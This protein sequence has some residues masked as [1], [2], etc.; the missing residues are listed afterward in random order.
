[1]GRQLGWQG[2]DPTPDP[3]PGPRGAALPARAEQA[4]LGVAVWLARRLSPTESRSKFPVS[5]WGRLSTA[6]ALGFLGHMGDKGKKQLRQGCLR[7][8]P[9]AEVRFLGNGSP[10][11]VGPPNSPNPHLLLVFS[12]PPPLRL[13]GVRAGGQETEPRCGRGRRGRRAPGCPS[14]EPACP[15]TPPRRVCAREGARGG[16]EMGQQVCFRPASACS[17]WNESFRWGCP[18]RSAPPGLPEP[19]GDAHGPAQA[20]GELRGRAAGRGRW[21]GRARG[22][23]PPGLRASGAP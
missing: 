20:E 8:E 5:A 10:A 13:P 11:R 1:M 19:R 16:P 9:Q 6:T 7:P 14:C 21:G 3:T 17:G 4:E 22:V 12:S 2:R 18:A 23:F 15:R